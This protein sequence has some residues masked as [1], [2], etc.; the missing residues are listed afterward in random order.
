[1]KT[2]AIIY[3]VVKTETVCEPVNGIRVTA[4]C[5]YNDHF[6]EFEFD[7]TEA[8]RQL[9]SEQLFELM[10]NGWTNCE[11]VCFLA[12]Y[13]RNNRTSKLFFLVDNDSNYGC[14]SSFNVKVDQ[15]SAV[16]YLRR[17]NMDVQILEYVRKNYN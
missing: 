10:E 1:M 2:N 14:G 17:F 11:E 16:E 5:Y 4:N 7:C 8:F 13:Y 15:D 3:Q 9:N 6:L 12:E